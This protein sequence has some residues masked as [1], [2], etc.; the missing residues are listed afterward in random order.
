MTHLHDLNLIRLFDFYLALM[1]LVGFYRRF[2]V[3][4]DVVFLLFAFVIRRWPRL[5]SRLVR[6]RGE[7][8]NW[9]TLGPLAVALALMTLQMIASRLVFPQATITLRDL[10]DP[11]WQLPLVIITIV[12]MLAVDFYFIIRVGRFDHSETVKYFDQAETWAGTLRANV[13]RIATF[14]RVDPERMVDE[15]VR[16]GLRQFGGTLSWAM[17]WVSTQVILRLLYGVTLWI[18]WAVKQ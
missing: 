3:Y 10:L 2:S 4:R 11:G 9:S 15:Q 1:L 12:P 8:M 18:L 6:H 13:V 17:W 16:D 7:V 14:G 5:L